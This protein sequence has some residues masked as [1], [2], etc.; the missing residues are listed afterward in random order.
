MD[1]KW[2]HSTLRSQNVQFIGA[3]L[4]LYVPGFNRQVFKYVEI[5]SEQSKKRKEQKKNKGGVLVADSGYN[6]QSPRNETPR[7]LQSKIGGK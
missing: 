3:Q 4:C 7:D 1:R 5:L 6:A 2:L